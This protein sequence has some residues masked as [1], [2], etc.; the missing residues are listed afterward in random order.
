MKQ[1]A[2]RLRSSTYSLRTGGHT[3]NHRLIHAFVLVTFTLIALGRVRALADGVGRYYATP[4]WDQTLPAST[5]FIVLSNFNSQA[6]LDRETGLVW[7][8]TPLKPLSSPV[9]RD[10]AVTGCWQATT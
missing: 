6:V 4:S 5:R 8:R 3:M 2:A 10:D 7:E 1:R 9:S